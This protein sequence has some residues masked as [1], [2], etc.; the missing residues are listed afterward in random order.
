[1]FVALVVCY[2]NRRIFACFKTV[3]LLQ[4]HLNIH[5]VWLCFS[6]HYIQGE[7]LNISMLFWYLVKSDVIVRYCTVAYTGR[8]IFYKLPDQSGHV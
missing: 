3:L 4:V 5:P 8:V 2:V 1:M 7:Q 6:E